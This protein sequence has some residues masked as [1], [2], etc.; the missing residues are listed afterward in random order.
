VI[1]PEGIIDGNRYEF[2]LRKVE[3]KYKGYNVIAER[4]YILNAL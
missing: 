3:Y 2:E 1:N 4:V